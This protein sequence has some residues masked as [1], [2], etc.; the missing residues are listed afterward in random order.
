MSNWFKKAV[1][2][3]PPYNLGGWS[4]KQSNERRRKLALQSRPRNWTLK[5]RYLS[6][7]RALQALTNITKD[8]T[9]KV[10]ALRDAKYFYDKYKQNKKKE[11][12][13]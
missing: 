12:K 1:K 6:A 8:E 10:K 5:H 11:Q 13:K 2:N 4:K 3:K 9:T 7:A